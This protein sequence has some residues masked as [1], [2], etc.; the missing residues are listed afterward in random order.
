[1]SPNKRHKDFT[2]DPECRKVRLIVTDTDTVLLDSQDVEMPYGHC[3]IAY[4]P[5]LTGGSCRPDEACLDIGEE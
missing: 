5:V 4:R 3:S 2:S 1:M